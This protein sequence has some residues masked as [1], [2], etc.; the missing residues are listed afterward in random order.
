MAKDSL[1]KGQ[2]LE[3][4]LSRD[5]YMKS[6]ILECYASFRNIINFLV[7]GERENTVIQNIFQRV[8]E[9]IEKEDLLTELNL[10]ALPNL[11]DRFVKLIECLMDNKKEVKDQIVILLLDMLEIVTRDIMEGDVEGLLDSSHGGS[12]GKD[13]RMTPL[14]Q[15]DQIFGR[16]QFPVTTD[17]EAWSEK[18]KSY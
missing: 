4:R 1:G 2:E 3:K 9:H 15:H 13:E 11:Y 14:D 12:Y 18:R 7:L 10:S 16:L 5:K 6:A 17:T 8:D